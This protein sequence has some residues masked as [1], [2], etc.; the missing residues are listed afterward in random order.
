MASWLAASF[1]E[2]DFVVVKMD[3]EGAEYPILEKLA[4]LG[5]LG[6]IDVLSIEAHSFGYTD[7]VRSAGELF[8][9]IQQ[10]APSMR[11]VKEGELH[12]GFDVYSKPPSAAT[13]RQQAQACNLTLT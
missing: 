11:V 3:V 13:I 10:A 6:L 5:K 12:S 4:G 2:A 9:L 8:E 7:K 1:T